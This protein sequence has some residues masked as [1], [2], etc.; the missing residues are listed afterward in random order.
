M[1]QKARDTAY[2]ETTSLLIL[3]VKWRKPLAIAV[4]LA[5]LASTI[6]SSSYFITP[7]FK[8]SVIFFPSATNSLS[9]AIMEQPSS[10]KQDILAFGEEERS[11]QMLQILNSDEIRETII[12]KYDLINHYKINADDEFPQTRLYDEFKN[13]INFSRTEFMSVKIEVLDAD[14][15]IAANIAN[16]I[17]SLLDSMKNKI[18]H[19]RAAEALAII[20][21]A[22]NEKLASLKAKEDS[23]QKLR[24]LGVIDYQSQAEILSAAYSQASGTFVNETASLTVLEKYKNEMDSSVINTKA[25]IKGAEAKIK[26]IQNDLNKLTQYGGASVGLNSEIIFDRQELSKLKEQYEKVK[27]DANQSLTHKFIVNKATKSEKKVYPVRWLIVL[28]S[29]VG[30][31][32]ISLMLIVGFQRFKQL[33]Y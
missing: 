28:L 14:P 26:N 18:Q 25:R 6:F 8:S 32:F 29:V 7:K 13:N 1:F 30:T 2:L 9:K 12:R 16:D 23:L 17:A 20:E 27:L 21:G 19:Q 33:E 31:F 22:Y 4:V 11:E 24:V 10:D 15:Q 3:I 5:A